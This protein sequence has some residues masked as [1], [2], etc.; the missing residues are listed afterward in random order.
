[1]ADR[2]V[3]VSKRPGFVVA[4]HEVPVSPHARHPMA[5]RK[6]P[7]F[8]ALHDVIWQQLGVEDQAGAV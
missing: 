1:M 7:I 3:V 2:I 8:T 5:V 6:D 4:I